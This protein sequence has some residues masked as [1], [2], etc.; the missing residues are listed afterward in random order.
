MVLCYGSVLASGPSRS[1]ACSRMGPA[2]T[3]GQPR[4]LS[5][6]Q[7][8]GP[9]SGIAR[10]SQ[11]R[12]R[13][14]RCLDSGGVPAGVGGVSAS[15]AR[16]GWVAYRGFENTPH[17]RCVGHLLR[18]CKDLQA[19]HPDAPWVAEVQ[20]VLQHGLALRKTLPC[21]QPQ[22]AR[23]RDGPQPTVRPAR[24]PARRAIAG[25]SSVSVPAEERNAAPPRQRS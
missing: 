3:D 9:G 15:G 21:G 5:R 12:A 23:S 18:R 19:A 22:R 8:L 25:R 20:A 1:A 17:Q 11:R 7:R 14:P 16:D 13:P 6:G 2:G 4:A 24:S 10:A